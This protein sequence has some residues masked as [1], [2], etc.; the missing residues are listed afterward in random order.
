M[1]ELMTLRDFFRQYFLTFLGGVFAAYFSLA[2]AV[3]LAF[4]TYFRDVPLA[5]VGLKIMLVGAL[6]ILLT[7]H[8]NF[9]ILRGRP[10]WVWVMVGIYLA[11]LVFVVPMVQYQPH[12]VL[13]GLALLFPF[14]GLLTLNSKV[15]RE[16]RT[17]LVGIR[18][19]RQS[20]KSTARSSSRM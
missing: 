8:S 9:M 7:V 16:M 2:L 10:S 12:K 6:L 17:K 14:L 1:N 13:Y 5:Q 3:A 4:V 15:Q 11:C 18:R 20:V 19:I